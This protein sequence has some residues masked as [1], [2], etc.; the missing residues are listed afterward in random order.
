MPRGR[1]KGDD[2]QLGPI[3]PMTKEDMASAL[4]K[5]FIPVV[6]PGKL[7]DSHHRVARLAASGLRQ[8]EISERTGYSTQRVWVLLQS[9]AMVEL[10]ATY[11]GKVDA[12]FERSQDEYYALATGNM[13]KAERQIGDRLDK[14]DDEG[15]DLPI[16]DLVSISRDAADRFGY[17]KRSTNVN[18]NADFAAE[19]EKAIARSGKVIEVTAE[20][21]KLKRRV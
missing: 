8:F 5:A 18:V 1:P 3:R 21:G 7:R 11:R 19:L 14:A 16:K 13:L 12:A 9:P 15:T 6:T 2:Y 10:I 20:D 4:Q 17:G